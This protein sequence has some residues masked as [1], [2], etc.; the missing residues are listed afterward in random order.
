M[1]KISRQRSSSKPTFEVSEDVTRIFKRFGG[2]QNASQRC[3]PRGP[4]AGIK[5]RQKHSCRRTLTGFDRAAAS[6]FA[7]GG[8]RANLRC[9]VQ[10]G[11]ECLSQLWDPLRCGSLDPSPQPRISIATSVAPTHNSVL[12]LRSSDFVAFLASVRISHQTSTW[13]LTDL[14]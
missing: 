3:L 4:R 11:E 6:F 13:L 12:A 2:Q 5:N 14:T 7:P 1:H 9:R 10:R 8:R